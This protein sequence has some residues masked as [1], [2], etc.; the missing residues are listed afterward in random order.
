M[1]NYEKYQLQWM[2]DH[3]YS[4]N[5]LMNELTELQYADP[6]DSDRI[7]ESVSDLFADW[8][9]DIGFGS[10]IWACRAEWEQCEGKG[11]R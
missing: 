10:E 7:T 9:S 4:L 8:E 2:I 11:R 1:T 6:E 3:G 5:D